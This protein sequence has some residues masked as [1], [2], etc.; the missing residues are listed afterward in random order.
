MS[1]V[2]I[3]IP[4]AIEDVGRDDPSRSTVRPAATIVK[5]KLQPNAAQLL[6]LF[7]ICYEMTRSVESECA[8]DGPD[9][10][11]RNFRITGN[12]PNSPEIPDS[13]NVSCGKDIGLEWRRING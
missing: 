13:S 5:R 10:V 7:D 4:S 9:A 2:S 8:E 6:G 12:C 1:D 3:L 11:I